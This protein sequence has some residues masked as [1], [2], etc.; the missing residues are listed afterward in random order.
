MP[1]LFESYEYLVTDS[2]FLTFFFP[3]DE[4]GKGKYS[5]KKKNGKLKKAKSGAKKS[6][7]YQNAVKDS[8]DIDVSE[9]EPCLDRSIPEMTE[10]PTE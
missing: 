8:M 7:A 1:N 10:D 2:Y 9:S 3:I 6:K 4:K 5:I